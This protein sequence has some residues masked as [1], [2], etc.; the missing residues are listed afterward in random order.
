[1]LLCHSQ[2]LLSC[3]SI[4]SVKSQTLCKGALPLVPCVAASASAVQKSGGI[5]YETAASTMDIS[6]ER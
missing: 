5:I 3:G 6:P 1:M 2:M 4:P